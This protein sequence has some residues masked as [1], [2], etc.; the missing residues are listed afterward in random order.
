MK[1][2]WKLQEKCIFR[3]DLK[4]NFITLHNARLS[5]NLQPQKTSG[6]GAQT[7][8]SVKHSSLCLWVY[9]RLTQFDT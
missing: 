7:Q 5:C 3:D 8:S 1:N 2:E 4:E 9:V 6:S